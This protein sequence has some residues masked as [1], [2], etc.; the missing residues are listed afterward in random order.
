L[1]P[2]RVCVFPED[3]RGIPHLP[4]PVQPSCRHPADILQTLLQQYSPLLDH[5]NKNTSEKKK[6]TQKHRT[7]LKRAW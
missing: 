3:R 1:V 6:G 4:T 5:R 7:I 2:I